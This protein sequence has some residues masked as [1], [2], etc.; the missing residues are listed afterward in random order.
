MDNKK[1]TFGSYLRELRQAADIG[2]RK[3][4]GLL[5]MRASSYSTLESDS[6]LDPIVTIYFDYL[7]MCL[8]ILPD[9]E[10]ALKLS[11]L[12]KDIKRNIFQ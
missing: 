9:S 11:N 1:E 8:G 10:E 12:A 7:C 6:C 5:N 3:F 2:Q 4:A